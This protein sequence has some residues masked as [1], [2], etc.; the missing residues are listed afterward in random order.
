MCSDHCLD[1]RKMF[2]ALLQVADE[3][4]LEDLREE[5]ELPFASW[6]N[7]TKTHHYLEVF[8]KQVIFSANRSALL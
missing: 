2:T 8:R 7:K 6:P 3:R 4:F 5:T 1:S